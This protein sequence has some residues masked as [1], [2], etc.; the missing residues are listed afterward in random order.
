MLKHTRI[1]TIIISFKTLLF[2]VSCIFYAQDIKLILVILK[3]R[4]EVVCCEQIARG[5]VSIFFK[6]CGFPFLVYTFSCAARSIHQLAS[7][8]GGLN[9]VVFFIVCKIFQWLCFVLGCKIFKK[10]LKTPLKYFEI[11]RPFPFR[12]SHISLP[13]IYFTFIYIYRE[14]KER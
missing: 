7:H 4:G 8:G 10:Y 13:F 6:C 2:C 12:S 9:A 1:F 11:F 3:L 14:R 5:D